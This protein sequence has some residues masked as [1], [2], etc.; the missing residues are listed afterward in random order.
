MLTIPLVLLLAPCEVR[1]KICF[2][3]CPAAVSCPICGCRLPE[4][5]LQIQS[6]TPF[7]EEPD[8][9]TMAAPGGLVQ[10]C[11][12]GM[13]PHRVVSVWIFACVKQQPNDLDMTEIRCQ[14]ECQ[15]AVR[16]AGARK[17][18]TGILDASQGHC[19][20]QIESSAAPDQGI[21][22]LKLTVQSGYLD[23]AVRIRSVIA[24]EID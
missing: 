22:R 12:M 1:T 4:N 10:R 21:H 18:P 19:H 13:A 3:F 15:M 9:F 24:E 16:T 8:Y 5:I 7:D 23:S 20:R 17:E 6:C 11:R 2:N 14:S